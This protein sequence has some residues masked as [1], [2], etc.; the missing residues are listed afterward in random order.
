MYKGRSKTPWVSFTFSALALA[1]SS[2]R[3]SAAEASDAGATEHVEVVG[4]AVSLDK[5]LKQQRNSDTIQSVVH[6]DG[7]AQLPDANVAE[8]VQRLPGIS[9]ERDQGE[10]RFVSVRGLGPDLNS[11]T[12]NGT[13]VPSPESKRRAVALDVLP[14]ELVQ[15]LS[16]I[17]TLTP[18]MDANSL[19]GT[20]DV[21]SLSAFDHDGLFYT[22]S[23]QAGYNKNTHQTSPKVSGAI[24]D[25]FSLGDGI[26]NFGVAAALS[27]NKRDFGSDN[28]ETAGDW[29]FN[30]GAKLNSFEQRVYDISRERAGGGLNFDY[31]PDD[32]TKLYLRTLYSR[33]KDSEI[34]N[35]DA[36]EFSNPQ[37][38][39]ELGKAKGKRKLKQRDETQEIQSYV[40]G[41]ERTLG[42]WTLSGQAGYSESSED[43]PAGISG[44]TFKSNSSFP[45]SGWYDSEKPRP[46][47]GAGF[48]DPANYTLD[49]V[50]VKKELTK[51][52]EKNL[53]LDLARDYDVDGYASQFKFGGKVSRRSKDNDTEAW[54]YKNFSKL[55]FSDEQ[56]NLGQFS[57]G[58]LDYS[59][60]RYGPGI[61]AGAIKDLLGGLNR[62]K[63]YNEQA[64]RVNDFT[65]HED[66][67]AAY[68][69]NTV[70]IDDWRFIAG[71]RYEGTEFDAKGTGIR[72]GVYEAQ[73]TRRNDHH[74]L[75]GLHAR[76][77]LAKNTQVRAAWTNAVVRP[78]FGQLAPGFVIEDDKAEFGNPNLKPLES[79]NFDLGIEHFM[80]QAGTVSAFLFYKDIK[81]FVYNNDLAGT[82]MWRDFTE[83][84]SYANGDSAKLYGL[85]LAYS[86][87]FDWLPAPWNGVIVGANSTFSRSNASIKGY[88]AASG[89][90]LKRDIDL[91]SQSNTVGNLMVG[92]ED[93][94]LSVRLSAN[95]KSAYLYELA[96]I[97]D[98]AHDTHVDA[99]T[100]VDFSARYSL[101]NNLQ[102]SFDAQNLTDQPYFVYSG[103]RRYNNQYEEYGPTYSVG[104][105]FTHF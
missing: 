81:N 41:G 76:Y 18:D 27:W 35:S 52:K 74:W 61:S 79:S 98:K 62:D 71:L 80:G 13:L 68:V 30:D 10:G 97:N 64:S 105:T 48:Y 22:A 36:I 12:I 102:V 2:E 21:E 42:L 40:L 19:G 72:N 51:D 63:F 37:A 87:K 89:R 25:R 73:H 70:D 17:K 11:V 85:E 23:T 55:G 47:I 20:V 94:K 84:H 91:P 58:E 57:K 46:I 60:G 101:T 4:Q 6:A 86:Q 33:F 99:Q 56:L 3:L 32:D 83:A 16:V 29:D 38:E 75:P 69:M 50:D 90:T 1:I 9:I 43:T 92:W 66:I 34:R 93:D 49:K 77:Q 45:G 14:S 28:V 8:A 54:T 96:G 44:A 24:S 7:V 39:G 104:L 31:K 59:L 53:R 78:T 26:D 100:F 65:M 95:Y 67:N 15:S 88:D 5:A 103:N 82:G